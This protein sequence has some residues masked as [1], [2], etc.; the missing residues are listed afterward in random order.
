MMR[1]ARCVSGTA[2][3]RAIASGLKGNV[4]FF[5][6]LRL[7]LSGFGR[8]AGSG[9]D[10]RGRFGAAAIAGAA[11]VNKRK[12]FEDDFQFALLL[13]RVLVFPLVELEA[14][15]HQERAALFH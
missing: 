1:D 2:R 10:R 8:T 3:S 9:S 6:R 15:F 12:A 5:G 7:R 13:V 11:G 4:V 14:A